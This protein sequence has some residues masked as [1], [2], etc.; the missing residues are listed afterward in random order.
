MRDA[1]EHA[2]ARTLPA[3]RDALALPQLNADATIVLGLDLHA[4]APVLPAFFFRT[5]PVYRTPFCLYG[6]GLRKRRM[7]AATWP[8][9][10]RSTPVTVMCVCLSMAMSIPVGT[11]NTTGC[12]YP[13]AKT[14]C[15]PF[16]SAR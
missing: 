8:T 9:S 3:A 15:L 1:A 10:C 14:T 4:F 5:S 13:S 16:T 11:S 7:L 2:Q 12:E 6:S